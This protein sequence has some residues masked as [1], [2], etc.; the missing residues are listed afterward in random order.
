MCTH[1][2]LSTF[3]LYIDSAFNVNYELSKQKEE[4]K[5]DLFPLSTIKR[6]QICVK[7]FEGSVNQSGSLLYK[8]LEF[9]FSVL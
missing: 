6:R 1:W 3:C 2:T 5:R 4:E 9:F 8:H 7:L